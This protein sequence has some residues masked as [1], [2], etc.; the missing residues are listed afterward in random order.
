MEFLYSY[1]SGFRAELTSVKDGM[2]NFFSPSLIIIMLPGL[3]CPKYNVP[4]EYLA[5]AA[6]L[7]ILKDV[8]IN[9]IMRCNSF[10][11]IFIKF[12]FDFWFYSCWFCKKV[13]GYLLQWPTISKEYGSLRVALRTNHLFL[14]RRKITNKER[15]G[16]SFWPFSRSLRLLGG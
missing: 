15:D 8:R 12:K 9:V 10:C 2:E 3:A 5:Y 11:F 6:K 1:H 14:A 4:L 7:L 13:C 16:Q